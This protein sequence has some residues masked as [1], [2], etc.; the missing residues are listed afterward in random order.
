MQHTQLILEYFKVEKDYVR[1]PMKKKVKH[2][3]TY[4][5]ILIC[6]NCIPEVVKS[7]L[8]PLGGSAPNE[9]AAPF[10]VIG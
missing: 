4:F 6:L 7:W 2:R 1:K 8:L 10:T 3:N 5:C 9:E